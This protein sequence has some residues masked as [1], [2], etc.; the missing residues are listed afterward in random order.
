MKNRKAIHTFASVIVLLIGSAIAFAHNGIEHVLG[1]V[2]TVSDTS[3]AV[4][5][6][7]NTT[8]NVLLDPSTTYSMNDA[9]ASLKDLKP[10]ERVV[11]NAKDNAQDKLVAVSVRWGAN[12]TAKSDHAAPK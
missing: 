3:I 6:V 2:S 12:S 5:T 8:V 11:V 10:G 7:K 1:T 4:R 9:K